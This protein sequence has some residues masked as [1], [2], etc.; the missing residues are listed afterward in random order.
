MFRFGKLFVVLFLSLTFS[1][2]GL[3]AKTLTQKQ[4]ELYQDKL[5][6]ETDTKLRI[7]YLRVLIIDAKNKKDRPYDPVSQFH[8]GNGAR[9]QQINLWA[10]RSERGQANS[11]GV[12]VNYEY[13]LGYIEKNHEA[14]LCDGIVS[15][16]SQVKR[17]YKQH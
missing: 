17:L 8:L 4:V 13:D 10:D 3:S 9:L 2:A 7:K 14:F 12:M 1:I 5:Q 15:A 11:W 6:K 16:S